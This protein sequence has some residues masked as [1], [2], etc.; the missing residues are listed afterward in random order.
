MNIIGLTK[1]IKWLNTVL[2][3]NTATSTEMGFE[4]TALSQIRDSV[5]D[6]FRFPASFSVISPITKASSPPSPSTL[7]LSASLQQYLVR[8]IDHYPTSDHR[9]FP[10]DTSCPNFVDFPHPSS[11]VFCFLFVL[12]FW[13]WDLHRGIRTKK[14]IDFG[15]KQFLLTSKAR[16]MER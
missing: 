14:A 16:I 12:P 13:Q 11:C 3:T 15:A 10:L 6:D 8:R 5:F 2:L 7:L 4:G 9:N 1:F